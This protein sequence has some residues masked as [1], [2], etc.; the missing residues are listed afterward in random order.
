LDEVYAGIKG[1]S[2]NLYSVNK[3]TLDQASVIT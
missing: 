1:K 2:I 3:L